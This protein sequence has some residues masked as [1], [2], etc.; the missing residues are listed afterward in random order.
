MKRSLT[1]NSDHYLRTET[2]PLC[3]VCKDD[4]SHEL[5]YV[6]GVCREE[7]TDFTRLFYY[8]DDFSKLQRYYFDAMTFRNIDPFLF[9][10][11]SPIFAFST[12][13]LESSSRDARYTIPYV[14][15]SE[16]SSSQASQIRKFLSSHSAEARV[17][18]ILLAS[19]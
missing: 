15:P 9:T 8:I 7:Y 11:A 17:G 18:A 12:Q 1:P 4:N 10:P 19:L 6:C 3:I 14:I 2:Y 16:L 5:R 13:F